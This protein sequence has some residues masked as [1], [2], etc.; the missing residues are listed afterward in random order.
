MDQIII[1]A[2]IASLTSLVISIITLIQ[3]LQAQRSQRKQFEKTLNRNLTNTLYELRL[4]TY[5]QAFEITDRIHK[6]KGGNYEPDTIKEALK[7]LLDWKKGVVDLI[8]SVEALE[9]FIILRDT[10]M[11]NPETQDAYSI[12]QVDKISANTKD[13]RRQLRRDIGFLFREEKERRKKCN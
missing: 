11:K 8:I 7:D 10:L 12:Q 2:I 13:F 6:I 3:S 4:T 5:P 9:S 1:P